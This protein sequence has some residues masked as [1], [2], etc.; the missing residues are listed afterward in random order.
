MSDGNPTDDAYRWCVY[1]KGDCWPER[2][3]QEHADDCPFVTG[4]FPLDPEHHRH[5]MCC[6]NC[7]REITD[8]YRHVPVRHMNGDGEIP[9]YECVCD[10]CAIADL[11][12]AGPES[13]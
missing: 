9:V 5:G 13:A 6:A 8:Y 7:G 2:E 12:E 10:D 1:C 3:H 11:I 4:R